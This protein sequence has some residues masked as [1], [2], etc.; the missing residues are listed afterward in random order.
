MAQRFDDFPAY[1]DYPVDCGGVVLS[2][3]PPGSLPFVRSVWE[4]FHGI[5]LDRTERHFINQDVC[6]LKKQIHQNNFH[7]NI[8]EGGFIAKVKRKLLNRRGK[9]CG[10]AEVEGSHKPNPQ[11]KKKL[12]KMSSRPRRYSDWFNNKG[13][14][15]FPRR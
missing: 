11:P 15:L 9:V 6:R 2:D 8:T 1:F 12:T 5:K 14:G 13:S 10:E 7:A 4:L 3:E